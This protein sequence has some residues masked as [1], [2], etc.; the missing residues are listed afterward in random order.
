[1]VDFA[2]N[3]KSLALLLGVAAGF[4]FL[5]SFLLGAGLSENRTLPIAMFFTLTLIAVAI[6]LFAETK[7]S[8]KQK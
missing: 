6:V 5:I 3:K 1:M 8:G 4:V 2:D 7:R